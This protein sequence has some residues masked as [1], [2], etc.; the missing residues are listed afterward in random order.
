MCVGSGI[1][2]IEKE[3]ESGDRG[4][5]KGERYIGRERQGREGGRVRVEIER[6]RKMRRGERKKRRDKEGRDVI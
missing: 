4:G 6:E 2:E 5:R 1:R 3:K